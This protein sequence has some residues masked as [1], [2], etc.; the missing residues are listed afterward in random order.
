MAEPKILIVYASRTGNTEKLAQA[1][2]E[3]A[4]SAGGVSVELKRARDTKPSDADADAF[5]FWSHSAFEYMAGELKSLFED[6]YIV[7]D[8]LAGKPVLL[9]TTGQGGQSSTLASI[10]RDVGVF[11]PGQDWY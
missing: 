7:R 10:D 6:F 11:N 5:A 3:G 4:R 8:K 9:F 1:V 2:A